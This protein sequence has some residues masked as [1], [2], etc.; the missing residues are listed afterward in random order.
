MRVGP[1]FYASIAL[2]G[3]VGWPFLLA[4]VLRND[5]GILIVLVLANT[6]LAIT[7]WRYVSSPSLSFFGA[8]EVVAST[9]MTGCA[10]VTILFVPVVLWFVY[11][12]AVFHTAIGIVR[13]R[14]AAQTAWIGL[15]HRFVAKPK[16]EPFIPFAGVD[17]GIRCSVCGV[18]ITSGDR[19]VCQ[20][21]RLC[22]KHLV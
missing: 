17:S 18:A 12:A 16:P 9:M 3:I 19:V 20:K 22:E 13:G 21:R 4:D 7:V 2:L 15:V 14:G 6:T 11:L 8:L 1:G 10:N 5:V